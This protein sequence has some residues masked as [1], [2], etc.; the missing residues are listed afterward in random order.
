MTVKHGFKGEKPYI[1]TFKGERFY[2]DS[3]KFDIDEV[4]HALGNN[5]RYGGQCLRFYSVAEHSLLVAMLCEQLGLADP[6]EGLLHDGHEAY[7]LDMPK[8]WKAVL[9]DYVKHEKRLELALRQQFRLSDTI[10]EGCKKADWIAL[11][12]ESRVLLPSKGDDFEWPPGI[13]EEANKLMDFQL[14]YWAPPVARDHFMATF[15]ELGGPRGFH[16]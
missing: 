1:S 13:R 12:V 5:C 4:G 10:S 15:A 16:R 11:A 3:P 6:F 14:N 9:P 7:L 8:P 2:L